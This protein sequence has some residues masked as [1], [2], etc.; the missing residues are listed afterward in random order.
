MG[1]H[2]MT[3]L[4]GGIFA[5]ASV[6][7]SARTVPA[8]ELLT[9]DEVY[10]E[11]TVTEA[12]IDPE[13]DL[14]VLEEEYD[15]S[16]EDAFSIIEEETDNASYLDFEDYVAEDLQD[17]AEDENA[18]T[19]I[20][21][22][23]DS[24]SGGVGTPEDPYRISSAEELAYLALECSRGEYFNSFTK[25]NYKLTASIDLSEH[26]WYPIGIREPNWGSFPYGF[27]GLFDGNGH[28]ISGL[29][30]D[31]SSAP[32]VTYGLF[33]AIYKG[34]VKG[35]TIQDCEIS[36][37]GD[38]DDYFG[39]TIGGLCG[40]AYKAVISDC[41]A[42]TN[43][44]V[45]N[46]ISS[47]IAGGF[48]GE[49]DTTTVSGCLSAG[50]IQAYANEAIFAGG[51][52][53][54]VRDEC[55]IESCGA[56][57][58]VSSKN[59]GRFA[60]ENPEYDGFFHC[61]G[62]F[63]GSIGNGYVD[64]SI[65]NCYAVGNVQAESEFSTEAGGFAGLCGAVFDSLQ[66]HNLVS[67]VSV[68]S[69]DPVHSMDG[70]LGF[71][72]SEE[73]ITDG[74]NS[75]EASNCIT[76]SCDHSGLFIGSGTLTRE[77]QKT[78]Y[79]MGSSRLV[80]FMCSR[81]GM[82]SAI[83]IDRNGYAGLKALE[84]FG[85]SGDAKPSKKQHKWYAWYDYIKI[86]STSNGEMRRE[87]EICRAYQSKIMTPASYGWPRP[88]KEGAALNDDTDMYRVLKGLKTVEYDGPLDT[89]ITSLTIPDTVWIEGRTYKVTAIA[90]EAFWW[91]KH[92]KTVTMGK[93][94]EKIGAV[95]FKNCSQLTKVTI[96]AGVKK[97]GKMAFYK[98]KKLKTII[99]KSKK[100]TA[101][102][103]G[104]NAFKGTHAKAVVKVPK[105]KLKL[106][107]SI[108]KKRGVSKK[109]KIKGF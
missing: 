28:T 83:W 52:A 99:I 20:N 37:Q 60:Q 103:I 51:F 69:S 15:P 4:I 27:A 49:M 45:K 21:Y 64:I 50:H 23:S 78:Y 77:Y 31:I 9:V 98:C 12:Y 61:A 57:M 54:T 88:V 85:L 74:L 93:N 102:S 7:L 89:S 105:K 84:K 82:D 30:M 25:A 36:G 22:A 59:D 39:Y 3:L 86:S 33:G 94:I 1:K 13:E 90:D 55:S 41:A 96:G 106:Y 63:A 80:D 66:L 62:G 6:G 71:T 91:C 14:P 97:I 47:I 95:A 75:F 101:K 58:S 68:N 16:S 29:R 46:E 40:D 48:I 104:S 53:G 5:I 18:D 35:I 8:E 72:S 43:I 92:L 108:L 87:C 38:T 11:E 70:Y 81:L 2:M 76:L 42:N 56:E 109:A 107:K 10:K 32:I 67:C 19:W 24:F 79:D 100:L 26:L 17:A 73:F 34:E 44:Q 65:C